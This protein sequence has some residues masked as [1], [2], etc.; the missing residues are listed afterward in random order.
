MKKNKN[1][2]VVL[3]LLIFSA[4]GYCQQ[5][6]SVANNSA[7]INNLKFDYSIGEMVLVS[8]ERNASIIVTQGQLQPTP[9]SAKGTPQAENTNVL[10]SNLIKVFPNP[11]ENVLNIES[12]E[13]QDVTINYQLFDGSG[14]LILN[15]SILWE[16]GPNKVIIELQP[17]AAGSYYLLIGKP[18]KGGNIENFSYKIQKTN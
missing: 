15:K 1:I 3:T 10:L 14:K 12:Y 17:Y 8:T 13:D 5:S 11:T 9:F 6:F 7:T 18:N 16:R 4:T 2:L